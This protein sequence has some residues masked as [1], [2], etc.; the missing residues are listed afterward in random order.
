MLKKTIAILSVLAM[1]LTGC[2][3][4]Q[5]E[6]NPN[7]VAVSDPFSGDASIAENPFMTRASY[8]VGI[9]A[10][11]AKLTG[12][13]VLEVPLNLNGDEGCEKVGIKIFIDGILQEFSPDNSETYSYNNIMSV[14]T[15]DT[16]YR[17]K[18][19]AKFDENVETHTI[20]AVSVYNPDFVPQP[21]LSLGNNHKGAAGGFRVLPIIDTQL[22]FSYSKVVLKAP[23]PTPATNEQMKKYNLKGE[24][25]E[26]FLLLQNDG[27]NTYALNEN[28]SS[29]SLQFVA[30]TQIAGSEKYRVSFYKNHELTAF[31]GDYLYLDIS[32]EGGKISISDIT[33]DNV[34]AGDFLYCIVVPTASFNEFAFA[35]KTDSVVVV[36]P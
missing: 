27:K 18:I 33:I 2:S 35:K 14:K 19:N 32:S 3:A 12:D 4:V 1:G 34:Q 23:S 13:S 26:A 8:K 17:L 30:G 16:D 36:K 6:N 7:S 21:G 24:N 10:E 15:D 22:E 31:N 5:S 28:G 11:N 29:V 9:N 25:S 20:S